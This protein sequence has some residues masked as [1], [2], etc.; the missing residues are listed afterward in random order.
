[1]IKLLGKYEVVVASDVSGK[2]DGI[3]IEIWEDGEML[4]DIFRDDTRKTRQ[5]ST[6]SNDIDIELIEAALAKF[7]E[8]IPWDF[9]E[10]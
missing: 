10:Y 7:K 9:I 4:M 3:G 5:L 8:E 1:M 2:R 6:F